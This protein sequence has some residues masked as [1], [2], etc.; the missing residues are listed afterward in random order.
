MN[1]LV[2]ELRENGIETQIMALHCRGCY[3][4]GAKIIFINQELPEE[5]MKWTLYHE[6]KHGMDHTEFAS[7]YKMQVWHSKMEAEANSY[8]LNRIIEEHDGYY[9]YSQV[10]ETFKLDPGW[11]LKLVK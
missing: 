8:M 5:E 10:T 6:L 3:V 2:E 11:N 7:L 9:N 4:P 1:D